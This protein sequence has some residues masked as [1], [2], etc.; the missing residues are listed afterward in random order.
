MVNYF[1][2]YMK[3]RRKGGRK[4]VEK[5]EKIEEEEEE[6]EDGLS[7]LNL[8]QQIEVPAE[9]SIDSLLQTRKK[10][11][12]NIIIQSPTKTDVSD[13]STEDPEFVPPI[14]ITS[15]VPRDGST[16]DFSQGNFPFRIFDIL[17][18]PQ[19]APSHCV[20]RLKQWQWLSLKYNSD[21]FYPSLTVFFSLVQEMILKKSDE[22]GQ[23]LLKYIQKF[24][25]KS[26]NFEIWFDFVR[27][28]M[29]SSIQSVVCLLS[30]G[31]PEMFSYETNSELN[32]ILDKI[33]LLNISGMIC[34][35]ISENPMYGPVVI[36]FRE[37]MTKYEYSE[38]QIQNYV[39]T[40]YDLIFDVPTENISLFVSMFP[41]EGIG[42]KIIHHVTI[43]F[44]LFLLGLD[45]IPENA[46]LFDLAKS[47]NAVK[48]LCESLDTKDLNKASGVIALSE[49]ALVTGIKLGIATQ[50]IINLMIRNLKF[51]INC[52]DPGILTILKEQIHVTRTQFETYV[53]SSQILDMITHI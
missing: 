2:I 17:G 25:K 7:E 26:L 16:F 11:L 20:P 5:K 21:N 9:F 53:Q 40:C 33:V 24:P 1:H 37:I 6:E 32:D 27:E 48:K 41:L 4:K 52:S 45:D 36:N 23:V 35:A 39:E 14:S 31:D 34:P 3:S 49:R 44:A 51:S 47:I 22:I 28:A 43:K 42:I 38:N 19:I 30:L 50:E 13:S 29:H 18:C 46:S 10:D 8:S 12:S 15:Y